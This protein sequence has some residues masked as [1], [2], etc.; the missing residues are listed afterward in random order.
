MK[1]I[2]EVVR[3]SICR[4]GVLRTQVTE[5]SHAVDAVRHVRRE[6][7]MWANYPQFQLVSYKITPVK[8]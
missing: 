3:P 2:V 6:Q 1:F 7:A 8:G 5:F 4:R